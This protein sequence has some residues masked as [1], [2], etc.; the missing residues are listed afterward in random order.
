M[1]RIAGSPRLTIARRG[2]GAAAQLAHRRADRRERVLVQA[3]GWFHRAVRGAVEV[4]AVD[5]VEHAG[6]AALLEQHVDPG[7]LHRFG[8]EPA[9][10]S[11]CANSPRDSSAK[12]QVLDVE[13]GG[14]GDGHGVSVPL[15]QVLLGRLAARTRGAIG[16]S[17]RSARGGLRAPRQKARK[18]PAWRT[19]VAAN[20]AV[21]IHGRGG[22][23]VVTAG[24]DMVPDERTVTVGVGGAP[25]CLTTPTT[26]SWSARRSRRSTRRAPCSPHAQLEAVARGPGLAPP[27]FAPRPPPRSAA[28]A[29]PAGVRELLA[30]PRRNRARGG[31]SGRHTRAPINDA[32]PGRRPHGAGPDG[33]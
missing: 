3:P 32:S 20:A 13:P 17:P 28:S 14:E 10:R 9:G 29:S 25:P 18:A 15:S 4:Y 23:G 8:I 33:G 5:V 26:A 31:R 22:Q 30:V 24:G 27:P 19:M 16:Q 1:S 12:L 21:R 6:R 11:R 7:H 2:K